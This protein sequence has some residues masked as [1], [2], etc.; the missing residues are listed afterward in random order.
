MDKTNKHAQSAALRERIQ[1]LS[2]LVLVEYER[3]TVAESEDLRKKF[4]EAGC[5]FRVYKNSIVRY[6][7]VGTRHEPV[8]P[9][10]AGVTGLAYNANDPGAPAR[11]ARDYAKT[12]D[13]VRIKGG[14]IDGEMLDP[15]RTASLADMPGPRE[16]K[17]QFLMLLK[18]PATQMVQ[19][20]QASTRDFLRVLNAKKAK[21]EGA[22]A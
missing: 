2:A 7:V 6:A 21:D 5:S 13:K 19:V 16:I 11:V 17:A 1:G 15:V 22:A 12:N 18:T 10:L 3:L 4:R 8:V 9:L 14:V 20:I